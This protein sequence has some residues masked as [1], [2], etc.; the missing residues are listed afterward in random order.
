MSSPDSDLWYIAAV[1]EPGQLVQEGSHA[2]VDQAFHHVGHRTPGE[3]DALHSRF[4]LNNV[5]K[6]I[7]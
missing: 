7:C 6:N 2:D 4:F 1:E 3:K 5:A